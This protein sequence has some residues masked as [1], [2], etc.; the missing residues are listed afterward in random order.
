MLHCENSECRQLR[1]L[2]PSETS[3]K[4]TG[5][6]QSSPLPNASHL[7]RAADDANRVS[8]LGL[9]V[10]IPQETAVPLGGDGAR[11]TSVRAAQLSFSTGSGAP[12]D[13]QPPPPA[14]K[15]RRLR[16]G[17]RRGG[18][19]PPRGRT[20]EGLP[21]TRDPLAGPGS[22]ASPSPRALGR[23]GG[24]RGS[25]GGGVRAGPGWAAAAA[26]GKERGRQRSGGATWA[27]SAAAPARP[28]GNRPQTRAAGGE[29]LLPAPS[30]RRE[31][32]C[33][34]SCHLRSRGQGTEP[35]GTDGQQKIPSSF[36]EEAARSARSQSEGG[37]APSGSILH[38]VQ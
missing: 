36:L 28:P 11:K 13:T 8:E 16:A 24:T 29:R 10:V 22:A 17:R 14:T 33:G 31:G 23:R 34:P 37:R 20:A 6:A 35:C 19:A 15:G 38:S 4:P 32:G 7:Y 25:A 26:A 5:R 18:D 12:G 1:A 2:P 9:R 21:L 3:A 30:R 27:R